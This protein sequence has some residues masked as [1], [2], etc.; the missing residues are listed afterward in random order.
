MLALPY[1][2]GFYTTRY[3]TAESPEAAE[4]L[5]LA[6]L[7]SDPSLQ[8]PGDIEMPL[9]ARVYFEKIEEVP[10]DT[11]QVPNSGFTF[12]EMGT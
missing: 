8:L 10:N 5:A 4:M 6:V 7:R 2:I 11:P 3:V 9:D 1:T 12:Y